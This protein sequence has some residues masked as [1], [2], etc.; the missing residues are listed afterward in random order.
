MDDI[1]L[2][3][4]FTEFEMAWLKKLALDNDMTI[5]EI[6]D[7]VKKVAADGVAKNI[8]DASKELFVHVRT[9]QGRNEP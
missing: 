8:I 7:Y 4:P 6:G 1:E 3:H 5:D 9:S 2:E